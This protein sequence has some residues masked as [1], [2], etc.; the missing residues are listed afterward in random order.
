MFS[1]TVLSTYTQGQINEGHR[2]C[3]PHA[4][5]TL[6]QSHFY[7]SVPKAVIGQKNVLVLYVCVPPYVF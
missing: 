7:C 4:P 2:V 5:H 3:S 6:N 1:T